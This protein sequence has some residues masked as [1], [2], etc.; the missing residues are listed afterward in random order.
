MAGRHK[1]QLS[2][3]ILQPRFRQALD[4]RAA[5]VTHAAFMDDQH[6]EGRTIVVVD[7]SAP[8][9]LDDLDRH[10]G[11]ARGSAADGVG[12]RNLHDRIGRMARGSTIEFARPI[13][14]GRFGWR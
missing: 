10:A 8:V 3:A 13:A 4:Y 2:A 14:I 7:S 6:V 11:P 1:N 9:V 12:W 5:I